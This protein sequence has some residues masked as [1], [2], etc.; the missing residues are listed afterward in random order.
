VVVAIDHNEGTTADAVDRIG[1]DVLHP[2]GAI[3]APVCGALSSI[4]G[5]LTVQAVP[6]PGADAVRQ[7]VD[8]RAGLP[9]AHEVRQT[10]QRLRR[11]LYTQA[12]HH[13]IGT[14]FAVIIE[15]IVQN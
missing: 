14:F 13:F 15:T 7:A 8:H 4:G 2:T 11:R 12:I 1:A 10:D 5:R 3:V 9:R 6:L